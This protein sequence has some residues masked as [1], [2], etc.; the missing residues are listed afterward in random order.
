MSH[1]ISQ[2]PCAKGCQLWRDAVLVAGK[3]L[4][5][6]GRAKVALNQVGPYAIVVLLLFGFAFDQDRAL[7]VQAA[8]GLYWMG[9]MFSGLLAVQRSLS[10]ESADAAMDSLRLSRLEPAGIFLGKVAAVSAQLVVLE[11]LLAG[12]VLV[13]FHSHFAGPGLLV[14]SAALST[15]G[16]AAA[17][18]AYGAL[19][20]GL[21]VRETLLPLLLAPVLAPVVLGAT[22]AWRAA[23]GLS[24]GGGWR[25]LA[26][27]GC[28]AAIYLAG[29]AV[30][31]GALMEEA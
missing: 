14:A 31:F 30:G 18:V 4:R 28:F 11:A 19:C 22:E 24:H 25:W 1:R 9:V 27:L 20:R 2:E 17:G 12:G 3:D 13:L 15:A 26:L 23:L 8:P 5:I 7:L 10:V 29:G 6:E 21:R 16:V